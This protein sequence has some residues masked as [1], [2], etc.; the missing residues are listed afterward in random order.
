MF[1]RK[2]RILFL[3]E[4]NHC[5]SQIAEA[6]ANTLG[7]QWLEGRSAGLMPMDLD[8][9]AVEA[10]AEVKIDI[11]PRQ[12][13]ALD[14]DLFSWADLVVT[15]TDGILERCPPLPP[16]ARHKPWIIEDCAEGEGNCRA[17]RDDIRHRIES[18]IG[19]LRMLSRLDDADRSDE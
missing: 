16:Q 18:M 17:L 5:R 19:G 11:T 15:L 8:A 14:H 3:S 2:A 12:S 10:M 7:S 13:K 9:R 1:K 4:H 6:Y